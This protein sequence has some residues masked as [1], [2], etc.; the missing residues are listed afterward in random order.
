L[1]QEQAL[2]YAE[3]AQR[4]LAAAARGRRHSTKRETPGSNFIPVVITTHEVAKDATDLLMETRETAKFLEQSEGKIDQFIQAIIG[5]IEN[6][7]LIRLFNGLTFGDLD[8]V[9]QLARNQIA[10]AFEL[11]NS[12]PSNG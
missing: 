9:A 5:D 8:S 1:A 6:E 12:E 10:R 2:V 4:Q 3:F 11:W 7:D